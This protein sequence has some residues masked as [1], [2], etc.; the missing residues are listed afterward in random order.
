MTYGCNKIFIEVEK[1]LALNPSM[2]L[3]ELARNLGYSHPT[4]EKA[5]KSHAGMSFRKFQQKKRLEAAGLL[6]K[7]G[8]S[9]K[10][11]SI[12]LG[13]R[14]PGNY[15]RFVARAGGEPFSMLPTQESN[16]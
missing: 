2:H 9:I 16:E 4:V 3:Y 11:I 12:S 7:Q 10:S 1:Q 6:K 5:V 14:W 8:H 13:Y 15:S